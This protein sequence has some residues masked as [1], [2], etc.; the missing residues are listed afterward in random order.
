MTAK[1]AFHPSSRT[2][3]RQPGPRLRGPHLGLALA[4]L[5]VACI[6]WPTPAHAGGGPQNAVLI[7]DP[8]QPES[9]YLGN[10]Y[11]AARQIPDRNVLYLRPGATDYLTFARYNLDAVLG[12][13]AHRGLEDHI[14]YVILAP[15]PTFFVSAR[16]LVTDDACP[17]PITRLAISSAYAF[18]FMEDEILSATL[19]Y[20][21]RH[22]Y[23][24]TTDEAIAFSSQTAWYGG[25]PST[26]A[27]ARRFFI[28]SLLGYTGSGGNSV[29]ELLRMIDRSVQADGSGPD[30]TF[31]LMR[32]S[33]RIR[34]QPRDT[35]FNRIVDSVQRLGGKAEVIEGDLPLGHHDVMA[36]ITGRAT[37]DID[38]ADMTLLPGS[39][40]DHL[41]SFAATFEDRG[42]TKLSRWIA[43]GASSSAGTVEEPCAAGAGN[44]GKFPH[45]RLVVWYLQGLSLG[46]ALFRS[47]AWTPFQTLYYG[48]PLTQ[49]YARRPLVTLLDVPERPIRQ[50]VELAPLAAAA[51]PGAAIR[52]IELYVDGRRY[53]SVSPG[54]SFLVDPLLIGDGYHELHAVAIEDT[55]VAPQGHWHGALRVEA[56][57]RS[58]QLTVTPQQGDQRMAFE[59][60]VVA[61]GAPVHE[62]WLLQ[63]GRIVAASRESHSTWRIGG[64]RLGAGPVDLIAVAEFAD[65]RL[66]TSEPV[67]LAIAYEGELPSSPGAAIPRA[68]AYTA[69]ALPGHSLLL[70][71]PASDDDGD[72]L[73]VTMER[74]PAQATLESDGRSFLLRVPNEAH[75]TDELSFRASDGQHT[76]E[77]ATVQVRYC[78]APE[79][80]EQPRDV[81]VC[82]GATAEFGVSARGEPLAYQWYRDDVPLA[83]GNQA[84]LTIPRARAADVGRYRVI[85]TRLC[86]FVWNRVESASAELQLQAGPTCASRAYLPYAAREAR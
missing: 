16:N 20:N 23:F 68:H 13:M 42:Q 64:R 76:S 17:A 48:D 50:P 35:H 19:R 47:A 84:R 15:G 57:A 29:D 44:T 43:K 40:G 51:T 5:V 12:T 33:D 59:A 6:V 81:A 75:G 24:G 18:A 31:Y 46:E 80:L 2:P 21:D 79:I 45:P 8:G 39:Y 73:S 52:A 78:T 38:N 30:G 86:G 85:V 34:S 70:D 9:L 63:N 82:A 77:P 36:V 72:L 56:L 62:L 41:T 53:G 71:L 58:I 83:L 7:I 54:R 37:L 26:D 25:L 55:P 11:R 27:R 49:P 28:G 4:V 67:R 74:P 14:D 66:A 69:D 10:Y 60:H 32:T 3:R 22:R 65:G 61:S 1:D